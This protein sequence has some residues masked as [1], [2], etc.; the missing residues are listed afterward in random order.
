[1]SSYIQIFTSRYSMGMLPFLP[2]GLP[3]SVKI[4]EK[5]AR[6]AAR[7]PNSHSAMSKFVTF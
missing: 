4:S 7:K 3:A 6:S 1:M 5:R 2:L